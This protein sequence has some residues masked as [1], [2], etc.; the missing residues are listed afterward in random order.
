MKLSQHLTNLTT[1]HLALAIPLLRFLAQTT[2]FGLTSS[3]TPSPVFEVYADANLVDNSSR[4]FQIGHLTM[5]AGVYISWA[6]KQQ[7]TISLSTCEA[8][9][10][11]A[12]DSVQHALWI[13][14]S[15]AH[16]GEIKAEVAMPV[17]IANM[18]AIRIASNRAPTKRK[19]HIDVKH[20]FLIDHQAQGR[21][22][23]RYVSSDAN[24][25][26]VYEALQAAAPSHHRQVSIPRISSQTIKIA[27][28]QR[29]LLLHQS[30]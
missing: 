10:I 14:F 20:H 13:H 1:H 17:S 27:T 16:T 5:L 15:L 26:D 9:Y 18:E 21:I 2:N 11:A 19:K 22:D 24:A 8:E 3:C 6:S 30:K 12:K 25:A 7:R 23:I 29:Q 4:K 28:F